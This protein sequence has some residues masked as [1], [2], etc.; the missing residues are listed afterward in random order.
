PDLPDIDGAV[1]VLAG[2]DRGD[3]ARRLD[4]PAPE[5]MT[6]GNPWVLRL[7]LRRAKLQQGPGT[8]ARHGVHALVERLGPFLGFFVRNRDRGL[9]L[10]DP[11]KNVGEVLQRLVHDRAGQA[12]KFRVGIVVHVPRDAASD[13]RPAVFQ[14][15]YLVTYDRFRSKSF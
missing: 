15:M 14:A 12:T 3:D 11:S 8:T 13:R 2:A 9:E 5:P 6:S 1:H 10:Q 4:Q 7:F